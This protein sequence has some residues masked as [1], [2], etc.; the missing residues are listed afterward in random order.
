M[1]INDRIGRDIFITEPFV[2]FPMVIVTREN[3]SFIK[4]TFELNGRKVAVGKGYTSSNFL[5]TRYPGIIRIETEDDE[6]ALVLLSN[7]EVD[8]FIEHMAVALETMQKSGFNNLKIGG[9]TEFKFEHRIGID[10]K[11]PQAV[12]IIN[13]VLASISEE[14]HRAIYRKWL[15]IKYEQVIDYSLIWKIII[16][17]SLLLLLFMLWIFKLS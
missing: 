15:D 7:G 16:V 17:S 6:H 11:Y 8:A 14:E 9:I 3:V 1:D 2:S 12:S 4:E 10:P 5:Q 13:K